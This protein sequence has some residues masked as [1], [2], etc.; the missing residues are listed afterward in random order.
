[1][2]LTNSTSIIRGRRSFWGPRSEGEEDRLLG[3]E[4]GADL[5]TLE[6]KVVV[7]MGARAAGRKAAGCWASRCPAADW[8]SAAQRPTKQLPSPLSGS[9]PSHEP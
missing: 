5:R 3:A 6:A 4:P 9:E 2:Y 1:M 8:R 7:A